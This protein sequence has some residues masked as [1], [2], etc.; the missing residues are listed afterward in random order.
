MA[1][2]IGVSMLEISICFQAIMCA[3][4]DTQTYSDGGW[5]CSISILC[6]DTSFDVSRFS[7]LIYVRSSEKMYGK[8]TT[9]AFQKT[10]TLPTSRSG[11]MNK[12]ALVMYIHIA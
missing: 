12:L 3:C 9:H 2:G 7:S 10:P 11:I 5:L 4:Y 1:I 6:T 8:I